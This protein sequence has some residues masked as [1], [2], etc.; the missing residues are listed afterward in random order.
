[1]FFPALLALARWR[2]WV[3]ISAAA[4][5]HGAALALLPHILPPGACASALV[6]RPIWGGGLGGSWLLTAYFILPFMAGIGLALHRAQIAGPLSRVP[7]AGRA[8]IALAALWSM[9]GAFVSVDAIF[10]A[11]SAALL[12]CALAS[13]QG[14]LARRTPLWLGRI[15]Y[16][17]YLVHVVVFL[18]AI[19]FLANGHTI[20]WLPAGSL[21]AG[22]VAAAI[23][24][25]SVFNRTIEEPAR[26]LARRISTLP[27][28]PAT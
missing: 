4:A 1:M 10:T 3:A 13:D 17:L 5:V 15:S 2:F 23:V 20:N 18:A 9:N 25:A 11:G 8:C 21:L 16:S 6:C 7:P 22:L 26:V 27:G 24:I 28:P 12:A 14:F 19:Y